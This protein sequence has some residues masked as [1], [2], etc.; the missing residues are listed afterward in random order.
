[1]KVLIQIAVAFFVVPFCLF[2]SIIEAEE[3][4]K[5]I[6][7]F[8]MLLTLSGSYA[9]A[10]EDQRAGINEAL[11]NHPLANSVKIVFADS[12]NDPKVAISEFNKMIVA[13]EVSAVLINRA[14]VAIPLNSLS[15]KYSMPII[16]VVGHNEFVPQNKF[17]FQVWPM[18]RDE[19]EFLASKSIASGERSF[20]VVYAEDE[21]MTSVS[22]GFRESAVKL[23]GDVV[24]FESILASEFDIRSIILKMRRKVPDAIFLNV[25]VPQIAPLVR[26][27]RELGFKGRV[28]SNI[29][30][31]RPEVLNSAG[32]EV[33]EGIRYSEINTEAP[34]L[35][36]SLGLTDNQSI[37][38][39]G[40]SS[41]VGMILLLQASADLNSGESFYDA[42]LR[43]REVIT[44]DTSYPIENRYI[45]FPLTI[46]EIN[47]GTPVQVD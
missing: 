43:Q 25:S 7:K 21:Y 41:Y 15:K 24:F 8:G 33:F 29:Y 12:L 42:M 22:Q 17:A 19:G 45:K 40:L 46:K 32:V 9:V 38:A 39:L 3:V 18:A 10:G 23:G 47:N 16:G 31:S 5:P 13:D 35:K 34:K 28:L 44:P 1:M 36:K 2:T 20:A 30:V 26:Q 37:P 6:L 14:K 27:V 11:K 4:K